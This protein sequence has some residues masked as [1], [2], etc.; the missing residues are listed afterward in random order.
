MISDFSS[1]YQHW[2][3]AR[4]K[5]HIQYVN[6]KGNTADKAIGIKA[7]Q[8]ELCTFIAAGHCYRILLDPK[9]LDQG[10]LHAGMLC[11]RRII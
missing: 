11:D 9:H 7:N 8:V 4:H 6:C 5:P 3:N 10:P 1:Y 2:Y